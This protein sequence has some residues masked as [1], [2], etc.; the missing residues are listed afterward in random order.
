MSI[1][2][3][4]R[5]LLA[6]SPIIIIYFFFRILIGKEER[7]RFLEK[8]TLLNSKKTNKEVIWFHACSVGETKSIYGLIKRFL[9]DGYFVL[10]T[11]NTYLSSVDVKEAFGQSVTHQYLPLD[12]N[13]FVKRFLRH[14][15]PRMAIFTES[16][17][18]P[19][20]INNTSKNKIPLYLIQAKISEKSFIRWKKY[21]SNLHKDL[22]K[23]FN[24][25]IAQSH[26]DKKKFLYHVGIP[27]E[28]VNNLKYCAPKLK[29]NLAQEKKLKILLKNKFVIT[30]ISTHKGEEKLLIS[31]LQNLILKRKNL[32]LILQPRH[33]DRA[34]KIIKEINNTNFNIKQKSLNEFPDNKTNIYIFDTFGESGL[35][36]SIS[37]IV[38]LGG[39]LVPIG[40]HNLIEPAKFGKCIISGPY[41]SKI[42]EM[43]ENFKIRNAIIVL[44]KI[45]NIE[46]KILSLLKNKNNIKFYEKRA[47]ELTLKLKDSVGFIYNKLRI[48][49]DN[50]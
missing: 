13:L 11:T 5:L 39:T 24:F 10:I 28:G 49:N 47:K 35:A 4:N 8:L 15:K 3:Y 41:H 38:I 36:I 14:W 25:I 42:I 19:N 48:K 18:W 46:N 33:P 21:A 30:A 12:F 32:L 6:L 7:K 50:S 22:L 17:I 29:V 43:I 1:K 37:N 16:E 40:G 45:N 2:L 20:L 26:L 31:N 23:K 34:N 27:V 44:E 9:N